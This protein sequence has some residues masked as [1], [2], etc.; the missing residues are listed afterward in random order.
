MSLIVLAE[1]ILEFQKM[2]EANDLQLVSIFQMYSTIQN[3][4]AVCPGAWRHLINVES[5]RVGLVIVNKLIGDISLENNL[6]DSVWKSSG[7]HMYVC[8]RLT[9]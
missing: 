1:K 9:C 2:Q 6:L 8:L 5:M 7:W 4:E 3:T